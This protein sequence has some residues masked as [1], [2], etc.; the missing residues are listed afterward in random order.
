MRILGID[1]GTK[2]IGLAMSDPL[3][4][5][6]QGLPTLER[7]DI[8]SDINKLCE[9]VNENGIATIVMGLPKN[10]NNTLGEKAREVLRFVEIMKTRISVPIE[11]LDERLSTVMGNNALRQGKLSLKKRKKK[12]DMVAAQLILQKFLDSKESRLGRE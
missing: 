12:V 1:Y 2:R 7:T 6:A 11:M 5:I 10:M 8:D 9:L 4:I 3:E